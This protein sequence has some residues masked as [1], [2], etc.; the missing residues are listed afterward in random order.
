MTKIQ[1]YKNKIIKNTK[2][3]TIHDRRFDSFKESC[4]LLRQ[5]SIPDCRAVAWQRIKR[6]IA[7]SLQTI[8]SLFLCVQ[9]KR[10]GRDE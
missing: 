7:C 2:V 1:N 8:S 5:E 3:T 10:Q 6:Y 4:V 9:R